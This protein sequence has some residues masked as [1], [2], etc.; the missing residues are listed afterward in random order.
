MEIEQIIKQ[1]TWLDDER[2]KDKSALAL[3]EDRLDN[4]ENNIQ[5][6]LQQIKEVG[7]DVTRLKSVTSRLDSM[8][9]GLLK[10]KKEARKLVDDLGKEIQRRNEEAEKIRKVEINSLDTSIQEVRKD[11]SSIGELKRSIQLRSE[12]NNRLVRGIDELKEQ[13]NSIQRGAEEN[14]H[15]FKVLED[16]RRQD[17]KRLTDVQGEL[18]ALR[19]HSD[20][21]RS[22]IDLF[23]TT[24][25]KMETRVGETETSEVERK[26][27]QS[28]FLEET[29]LSQVE[30]DKRWKEW[31][32]KIDTIEK[33]TVEIEATLQT[34]DSTNRS[35]VRTQQVIEELSQKVERRLSEMTE[36][37]R[38]ADER[39]RQEW[40]TFK[41]DD[42]KRW[43][44]YTLIQEEQRGELGRHNE[45]LTERLTII[46]DSMQE[47]HD[48]IELANE[49]T[50]KR[51]QSLLAAVHD[52]VSVYEHH[53]GRQTA[54]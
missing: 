8:D 50:E 12:E 46:E 20:E 19:K 25:R 54:K 43:T 47:I 26:K 42:Q 49:L 33:Q 40:V 23:N 6:V 30:R 5:T 38:L 3:I 10:Q 52:W 53:F 48:V 41:A 32:S 39:F 9:E 22:Q 34:L 35:V 17:S 13:I 14:S 4:I 29:A 16:G 24:M 37:Q 45:K 21:H 44:N 7:S 31:Q 2:R 15:Q 51:L 27:A 28:K 36:I 11:I 1:V 18:A